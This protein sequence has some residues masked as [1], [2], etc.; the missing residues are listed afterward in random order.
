MQEIVANGGSSERLLILAPFG[1]DGDLIA[2]LATGRG[3]EA[4]ATRD[5][6][7]FV[8]EFSQGLGAAVIT[9]EALHSANSG[10]IVRVIDE[11]QPWSDAPFVVI[12]S[13]ADAEERAKRT[14][15]LLQPLRNATIIERP[16]RP[17]TVASAF[18]AALRDRRRQYE[19]RE[20]LEAQ[21]ASE[22]ALRQ[23][24]RKYRELSADLEQRVQLRTQELIAANQEM[25][26]FT[27]SVSHDLRGPLRAIASTSMILKMDF[28]HALPP[29][30]ISQ[31]DRQV[32]AS[33][34]LADLIDDLLQLSRLSR[35]EMRRTTVDVTRIAQEIVADLRLHGIPENVNFDIHPG[36]TAE[37][38]PL[39]IR[40]A[41]LNLLDNAVKFSPYG[42]NVTVGSMGH[43]GSTTIFVRDM[44]IGF[45]NKYANKVFLPFERLVTDEQFP[46]T[47]IGLAN[48]HR[49]VKR[50]GGRIWVESEPGHG[51]TF[52]FT[53]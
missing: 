5:T 20:L 15:Q 23:S 1:R 3:F 33:K 14:V 51:S 4:L 49:I 37:G 25:E 21:R 30:A 52:F 34:K 45:E 16:V 44:G 31:L 18:D 17:S 46:G 39:L 53:L 10:E 22:D 27:Y 26:G 48:V 29:E 38:D 50:H 13:R 35:Q 40:L 36:L 28:G 43:N 12:T 41:L 42:G 47:G 6:T 2:K 7:H 19:V 9:E 11:Q 24:E 32:A 8:H